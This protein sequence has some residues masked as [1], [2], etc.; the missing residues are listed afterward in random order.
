M[1]IFALHRVLLFFMILLILL[2]ISFS[3]NFFPLLAPLHQMSLPDSFYH[4]FSNLLQGNFG[5]SQTNGQSIKDQITVAFPATM[6]LCFLAFLLAL[7][8]GI[9]LGVTA[10]MT[11]GRWPD[12]VISF[13]ALAGFSIP[14][15]V[16]ALLF[17]LF[18]SLHLNWLS[19]PEHFAVLSQT[20]H[21]TGLLLIDS[22]FS[23]GVNKTEH[24]INILKYLMLPVTVLAIPSFTEVIRLLRISTYDV[25]NENYMKAAATR[26]LSRF[27]MVFYYILPNALPPVMAKLG[28][29]F[30]T[31]L[32][33]AMIIELIFDC[34]GLGSWLI[35]A[36]INKDHAVLSI[37]IIAIGSVVS[38][39]NLIADLLGI[40]IAPPQKKEW[41][42]LR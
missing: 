29:Q 12:T 19:S 1:I 9:P 5:V 4:F 2:L 37:A 34:P 6:E 25:M 3:L 35:N 38:I 31:M 24:M 33:F 18:F 17:T 30:S 11:K 41:Y 28:W 40:L 39:I 15:F 27:N 13:L 32:S 26:G 10:G 7:F 8:T 22:W 20:E 23:K 36:L 21:L 42:A 16:M 14:V